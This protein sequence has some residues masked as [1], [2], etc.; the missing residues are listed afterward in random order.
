MRRM[1]GI[2]MSSHSLELRGEGHRVLANSYR[3]KAM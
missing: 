3:I 2:F 1:T